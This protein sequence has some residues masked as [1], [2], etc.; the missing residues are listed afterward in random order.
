M[1]TII[2]GLGNPILSDD[3]VGIRVSRELNERLKGSIMGQTGRVEVTEIYAGGIRLMDAMTGYER[4][5][6]IDALVAEERFPGEVLQLSLS[7]LLCTRNT[8]SVHDMNLPTAL[9]LGRMLGIPLP[10]EI[11]IWGIVAKDV[12]TFSDDLSEEVA[13]SVPA[14]VEMIVRDM[15]SSDGMNNR[16]RERT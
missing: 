11:R 9:E 15:E 14:V 8:V 13:G 1:K 4:A 3:G 7:D 6:I 12:E 10:S 5:V 2:I 16:Q